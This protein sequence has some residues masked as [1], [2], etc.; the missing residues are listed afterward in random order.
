MQVIQYRITTEL[1]E[2]DFDLIH[3]FLSHSYWAQSIPRATLWKALNNSLCFAALNAQNATLG[4]ARMISDYATYAY[5]ADVFVIPSARGQGLSKALLQA[6]VAHPQL[7]G[8]RR[9]TLVTRDA[10]ELY[11]QFGFTSL[12]TPDSYMEKWNPQVYIIEK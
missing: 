5:L 8:L 1:D 6:I 10:H 9:I 12:N 11:R 2:M 3:E 7:Q 4:F